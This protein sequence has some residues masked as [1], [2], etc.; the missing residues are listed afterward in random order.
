MGRR[1]TRGL[2]VAR[3]SFENQLNSFYPLSLTVS[4]SVLT[5]T[6]LRDPGQDLRLSTSCPESQH[7]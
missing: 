5:E 7:V 2:R 3:E 4:S 6:C 1:P